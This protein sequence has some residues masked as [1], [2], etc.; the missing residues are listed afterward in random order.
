VGAL[1]TINIATITYAATY[2]NG[3]APDLATLDG[4]EAGG[5]SCDHAQLINR[6]LGSGQRTGYIFTYT[7]RPIDGSQPVLTARAAANGCTTPGASGY[8][9]NADPITRGTTGQRSFY[10]DQ[11]GIIRWDESGT[12]TAD[13]PPLD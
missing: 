7:L 10:T 13:S 1:R 5:P 6:A 2:G 9:V 11:T 12:A 8:A 3:F 4:A